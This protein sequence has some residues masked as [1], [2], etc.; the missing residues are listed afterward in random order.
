MTDQL[1]E[2]V[3]TE[4]WGIE[5]GELCRRAGKTPQELGDEFEKLKESGELLGFAGLWMTPEQFDNSFHHLVET[6]A[7]RH[8]AEPAKASQPR[9]A[10]LKEAG[11]PLQG[12]P[13]DRWLTALDA[14]RI[15][16]IL[17]GGL[18]LY[19]FRLKLNPKQEALF[20]RVLPLLEAGGLEPPT[21]K[22]IAS[23]LAIPVPAATEILS[24]GAQAGLAIDVPPLTYAPSVI[25]RCRRIL[26]ELN[27][28]HPEGFAASH[29]RDALGTTRKY[30]V[31]ILEY[32][33]AVG[34]TRRVGDFRV[35]T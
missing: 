33:D 18:A 26:Q 16:R 8:A 30:A 15:V 1:V 24:L 22:I 29:A 13:L 17:P 27:D 3:R 21:A 12:K 7:K 28:A 14:R 9:E 20:A 34:F 5:T 11:V 6:L 19:D 25:A 4:P 10:V 35:V 2:W 31:P 23:Q 32:F